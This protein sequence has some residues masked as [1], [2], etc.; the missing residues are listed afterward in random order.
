[1][2]FA[3]RPRLTSEELAASLERA[4]AGRNSTHP[5]WIFGYGSLIWKPEL[6]FDRRV[7]ARVFGY[8]RQLCLRSIRYRGT[9]DCPGIVCG[10]DRGGSCSGVAY[11]LPLARQRVQLERLW[12]REMFMGSYDARWV[13]LRRLDE[14]EEFVGLAF[15][16][17]RDAPNYC[18]RLPEHELI[19]VLTRACGQ[20]GSSLDYL[21][22]TT[23]SLRAHGVPDPHLERLARVARKTVE[24]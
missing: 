22:R 21:L 12:E 24:R 17:R 9:D 7:P 19:D 13:Q 16:V 2:N 6:D 20:Y 14:N 15:V 23:E 4:F 11:R 8:H 5:V 18:G 3:R 1:M 10:L